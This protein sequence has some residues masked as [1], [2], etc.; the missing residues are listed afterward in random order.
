MRLSPLISGITDQPLP[1][2]A[3]REYV[4]RKPYGVYDNENS[5]NLSS[6]VAPVAERRTDAGRKEGGPSIN[7]SFVRAVAEKL[8]APETATFF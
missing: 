6:A 3:S 4:L 7:Q 1:D 8:S 2:S 5:D